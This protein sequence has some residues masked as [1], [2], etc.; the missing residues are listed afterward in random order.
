MLLKALN[1]ETPASARSES[2][3][4]AGAAAVSAE[5]GA[6]VAFGHQTSTR[7]TSSGGQGRRVLRVASGG[8]VCTD[9]SY[10]GDYPSCF[11]LEQTRIASW[12]FGTYR[13]GTA[14][15]SA[16]ATCHDS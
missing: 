9:V 4:S 16:H 13:C 6:H 10:I 2:A 12:Q 3:A 15:C 14:D 11:R 1:A 8:T 5:D 7:Q